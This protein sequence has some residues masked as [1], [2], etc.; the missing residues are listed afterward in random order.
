M[1]NIYYNWMYLDNLDWFKV[2]AANNVVHYLLTK[3][4]NGGTDWNLKP[5][6]VG[7]SLA[8]LGYGAID[9]FAK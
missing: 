1:R 8:C 4:L 9:K 2:Y 3:E 6:S 7:H 5:Q